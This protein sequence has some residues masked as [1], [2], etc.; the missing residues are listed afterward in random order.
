MRVHNIYGLGGLTLTNPNHIGQLTNDSQVTLRSQTPPSERS[1]FAA[2][3][4]PGVRLHLHLD[5]ATSYTRESVA[6]GRAIVAERRRNY[7]P[8]HDL[9]RINL[10]ALLIRQD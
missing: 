10:S 2:A 1:D 7:R 4:L 8:R 6:D 9:F 3:G 5:P